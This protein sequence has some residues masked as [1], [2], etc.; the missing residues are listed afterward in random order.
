MKNM[1]L[2]RVYSYRPPTRIELTVD[3]DG[4]EDVNV[5]DCYDTDVIKALAAGTMCLADGLGISPLHL[6]WRVLVSVL[7]RSVSRS[8][9]GGYKGTSK[10]FDCSEEPAEPTTGQVIPIQV[11][12]RTR[13]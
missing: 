10:E 4:R 12:N 5:F 7:R 6:A 1:Y 11:T 8:I 13:L 2:E 9:L 3:E